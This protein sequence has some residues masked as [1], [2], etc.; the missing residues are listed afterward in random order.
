MI[1]TK[2]ARPGNFPTL[3]TERLILRQMTLEDADF[4]FQHFGD[5]AVSRYLMD[6]PPVT[7]Y[8]RAQ[9]IIQFYLEP[10]EKTHNRWVM[11]RK[12]D[13]Q[14]IG[15]CGFHKWDRQHFRAEIGYDLSPSCWGQGYMMEALRTVISNGFAQMR[16][17]RIEALVYVENGR[18]IQLLR[19]LGFKQE[20]VLREYLYSD[21]RFYD[22]YLFALLQKEWE[23]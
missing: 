12:A 23:S 6:E 18:S 17:N 3:E 9:E 16:L 5:P 8:A 14:Y 10:E 19:R 1:M 22:H 4:V 7:E 15:T 21:G 13:H 2:N 20:G 11:V